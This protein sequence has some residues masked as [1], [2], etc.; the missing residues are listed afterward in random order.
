MSEKSVHH[1]RCVNNRGYIETSNAAKKKNL[2]KDKTLMSPKSCKGFAVL[3]LWEGEQYEEF[4]NENIFQDLNVCRWHE[5]TSCL[6]SELLGTFEIVFAMCRQHIADKRHRNITVRV[7]G[8]NP[9]R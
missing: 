1:L 8:I 9:E 6:K 7:V 5:R 2:C 3:D 4:V